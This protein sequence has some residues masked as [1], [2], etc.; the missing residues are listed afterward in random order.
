MI[1]WDKKNVD[2]AQGF[3]DAEM[4][5]AAG[6]QM[7]IP[8]LGWQDV[9]VGVDESVG[10]VSFFWSDRAIN[11]MKTKSK[12]NLV[13]KASGS[14]SADTGVSVALNGQM[15]SMNKRINGAV[16]AP[17]GS[18]LGVSATSDSGKYSGHG[19]YLSSTKASK[20]P[21][22]N[23]QASYAGSSMITYHRPEALFGRIGDMRTSQSDAFGNPG[24]GEENYLKNV[25]T[26][27]SVKDYYVSG[28]VTPEQTSL[29]AMQ[30]Q[31]EV[32]SAIA[33]LKAKGI[34]SI[35]GIPIEK[36]IV[37]LQ[38]AGNM[39]PDDLPPLYLPPNIR[40]IVDLPQSYEV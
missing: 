29:I 1:S 19:T 8:D 38:Q 4:F 24:Y 31:K 15:N 10:K 27:G 20:L 23:T 13:I 21:S 5:K 35:N 36:Y 39:H 9:R 26:W 22:H 30:S 28:G 18:G 34:V 7:G 33:K 25:L 17:G 6:D 32:D 37:T 2:N 40:P 3:T 14:G 16:Y 12:M 11:A